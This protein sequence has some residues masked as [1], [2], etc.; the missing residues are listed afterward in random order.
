[1]RRVSN[2]LAEGKGILKIAKEVGVGIGTVKRIVDG[3]VAAQVG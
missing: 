3:E 2:K 1:M